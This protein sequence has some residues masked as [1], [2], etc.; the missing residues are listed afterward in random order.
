ML[1]D[2]RFVSDDSNDAD[3]FH[4]K[5]AGKEYIFRLYFVD[6]PETDASF[7]ARVDAQAKYFGLTTAQTL[8]LGDFARRL[9]KEKLARPF[10]LRT[11]MQN[12][13]GRSRKKR[14]Y[15]FLGTSEGDPNC[16]GFQNST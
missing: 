8:Q 9:A 4:V 3:S 13:L 10:T 5:V 15:A 12:A 6:A 7:P 11:C 14:F 16:V 1:N 2:C